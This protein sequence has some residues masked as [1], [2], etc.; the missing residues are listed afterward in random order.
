VKDD[1]K[2]VQNFSFI[3]Y[4]YFSSHL[5]QNGCFTSYVVALKSK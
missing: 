5:A 1:V 4:H 3:S 2:M